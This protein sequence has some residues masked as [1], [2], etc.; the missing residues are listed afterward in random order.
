MF[1]IGYLAISVILIL[2]TT[3]FVVAGFLISG[4]M[5]FGLLMSLALDFSVIVV[6]AYNT[7]KLRDHYGN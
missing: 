5:P 7:W 1:L 2:Q 4:F 6:L 3:G